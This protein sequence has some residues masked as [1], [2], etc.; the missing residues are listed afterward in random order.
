MKF[1]LIFAVLPM[2]LAATTGTL[3]ARDAGKRAIEL[4]ARA[5]ACAE[6]ENC[7]EHAPDISV[8]DPCKCYPEYRVC[9]LAPYGW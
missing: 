8:C 1:S 7:T 4:A 3:K 2:A 6:L 5:D 9:G